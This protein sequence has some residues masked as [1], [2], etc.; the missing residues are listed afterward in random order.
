MDLSAFDFFARGVVIGLAIAAPVGPI[1]VL[2]IRRTLASGRLVGFVT[3]MGAATAD[4][5]Y[6]AAAAFGLTLISGLLLREQAW[7]RLIGGLALGYLGLRA[8][9]SAVAST[10]ARSGTETKRGL[11]GAYSSTVFLTLT[12]PT[13]ILSFAA[14]FAGLGVGSTSRG[15][16]GAALLVAGVFAGSAL[17]WLILSSTVT[18]LRSRF[19]PGIV[20]WV[21]RASG[22]VLLAFGLLALVS[23]VQLVH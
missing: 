9:F 1:G 10:P 17:W 8:I 12:N 20:G 3:G 15:Y 19:R 2:C 21:G 4:G 5:T 14:V 7:V 11:L 22:A 18:A 16:L 13:T 6:G 23:I